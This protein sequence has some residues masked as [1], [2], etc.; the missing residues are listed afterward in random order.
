MSEACSP[1]S[2]SAALQGGDGLLD[3]IVHERLELGAGELHGEMLR[4]V[5]VGGDEGQIDL[6]LGGAG[7]LDLR[8]LGRVLQ[9][10][11]RQ[12]VLAQVDALLLAE[13]VGQIVHDALVEVLAA[14]E[15][16]AVGR[17]D[18]EHAVADLE[19]GD[20]EGAAAEIVD[21]DLAGALLLQAV[22]ERGRGRLVDDAQHVE[23]GDLA[24]VLG[25]LALGVVEVGGHRDDG[26][27][28]LAAEIGLGRLLHLRAG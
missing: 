11:Q 7:Q 15:G 24:G 26:L 18:L 5:L 23:A 19:D 6:G 8:L 3:Q 22:G 16:V 25:G 21:G 17:L 28:H 13:L 2:F 1:A 4:P 10:L 27:G 12:P 9:A 20:V 14:E